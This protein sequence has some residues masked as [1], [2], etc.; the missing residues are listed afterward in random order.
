LLSLKESL[1]RT[2]KQ[3]GYAKK[4]TKMWPIGYV[5]ANMTRYKLRRS[6]ASFTKLDGIVDLAFSFRFLGISIKPKQVE[7][8]I[9]R[10]LKLLQ[11][12]KPK[13]V[14]EIGTAK[15]GTLFSFTRVAQPD[16]TLIS[17]DLPEAP[18]WGG[19]PA[20]KIPLYESFA[21]PC[22]KIH[23]IKRDSHDSVTLGVIKNILD[24]RKVDFLFIDGDHEYEGVKRD[25]EMYSVLVRN[26]G[27]IAFHDI[28][29]HHPETGCEVN[30]FWVELKEKYRYLELVKDWKQRW[31]GIG[32]I[33]VSHG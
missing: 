22:Q 4:V 29:P 13:V 15:G 32:V 17:I 26:G 30:K 18:F 24:N 5:R 7:E 19:Y 3:E 10:L 14:L 9:R 33:Y 2:I 1:K 8:E 20:W 16:A 21:L 12:I 23:L 25:F 27:I 31:A 28:C 11:N 6:V